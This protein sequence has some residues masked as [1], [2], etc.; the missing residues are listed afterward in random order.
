[1]RRI[2]RRDF[3]VPPTHRSAHD[4]KPAS[5]VGDL[6]VGELGIGGAAGATPR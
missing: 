2:S 6:M 5:Q 3:T 1:M 4:A